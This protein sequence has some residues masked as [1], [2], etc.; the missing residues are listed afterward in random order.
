MFN[1]YRQD[2]KDDYVEN[3]K[4]NSEKLAL[5]NKVYYKTDTITFSRL[6]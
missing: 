1:T 4:N 5:S 2:T 6:Y 3:T